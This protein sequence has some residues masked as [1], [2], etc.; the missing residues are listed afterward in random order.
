MNF[1]DLHELLRLEVLR[2]IESGDLTGTRLAQQTGFQQAHISN[3]LNRKRALSMEGLDRV[4]AAQGLTVE[5]ILPVAVSAGAEV[6][7][8]AETAPGEEI[9]LVPI[10]SPSAAA[11]EGEIRAAVIEAL[12]VAASRLLDNRARP[13]RRTAGW[14][15]F[16]ALRL[17]AQQAAAM[18][19]V[20]ASGTIAV[21]D[22]HYNSLA[23]YRA[24]E[25][26]LYAVRHGAGLL[27]RYVEFAEGWLVLRPSAMECA[28]QLIAV[29]PDEMPS[30]HIAGRVCLLIHD[31]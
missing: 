3:F 6:G 27:L 29:G 23:P 5:E 19:P 28:V 4:L 12:P 14:Q 7:A 30:D 31:L 24:H 9:A 11:E 10:V 17:D 16:V 2:R 15:R 21:I 22:R 20:L 25:P 26:T 13:S 18:E 1:Q 8:P